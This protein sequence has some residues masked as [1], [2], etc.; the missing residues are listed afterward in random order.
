[1]RSN[2]DFLCVG[3]LWSSPGWA[4]LL[5]EVEIESNAGVQWV[6]EFCC[7]GGA[8][9]AGGGAWGAAGARIRY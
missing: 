3:C 4:V 5:R 9:G 1:M 7:L 2:V 8:F 6:S